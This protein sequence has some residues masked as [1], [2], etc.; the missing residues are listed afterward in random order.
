MRAALARHDALLGT[1]VEA[2]HGQVIKSTGD[3]MVAVFAS[4]DVVGQNLSRR[5]PIYLPHLTKALKV[6]AG[7]LLKLIPKNG[8]GIE[9]KVGN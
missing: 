2:N 1:A 7:R 8:L 3:G 9:Q 6:L 5:Q 4:A